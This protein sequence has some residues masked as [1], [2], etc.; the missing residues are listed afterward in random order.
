MKMTIEIDCTAEEARAFM[1][2]PDVKPMQEAV[3]AKIET[4]MMGGI[5]AGSPDALMRT[6]LGALPTGAE[7]M[8]EAFMG[9]LKTG[10]TQR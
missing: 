4:Q 5:D 6:W 3:L 8:R 10:F 7:Q 2:L 9:L 1:G